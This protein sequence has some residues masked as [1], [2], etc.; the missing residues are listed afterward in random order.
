MWNQSKPVRE[1]AYD[2]GVHTATIYT[3]LKR[4][5]DGS[6]DRNQRLAYNASLAERRIQEGF[7]R[8]GQRSPK[9]ENVM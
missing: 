5:Q 1:I 6:I 4:G 8:R 7:K 9:K 3:E 2:L